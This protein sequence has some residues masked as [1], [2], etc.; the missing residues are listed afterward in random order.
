[1]LPATQVLAV[2]KLLPAK[3]LGRRERGGAEQDEQRKHLY[4]PH[5]FPSSDNASLNRRV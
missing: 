1:M 5:E 4:F 3:L 2:K